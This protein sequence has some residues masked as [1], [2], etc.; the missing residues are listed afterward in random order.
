MGSAG[1][2]A[3]SASGTTPK[4]GA[5]RPER[6][7]SVPPASNL[8][9][10]PVP[11]VAAPSAP[12]GIFVLEFPGDSLTTVYDYILPQPQVCGGNLFVV[13][14]KVDQGNGVYNWSSVDSQIAP[15]TKAGKKAN[16]I[17][18]GVSY[19][20]NT[21]TPNYVLNDPD[22]QSVSCQVSGVTQTY[23][24]YYSAVYKNDYKIFMKALMNKYGTDPNIGYIRFGFSQGGEVYPTCLSQMMS[25]SGYKTLAAFD[26]A[27]ESYITEMTQYEKTLQAGL[28]GHV[29]AL[30]TD[31]NQFGNPPQYSVTDWE[32][33][34]AVS[35]GIGFGNQGLDLS[36]VENYQSGKPC[37][38]D[39][40]SM[41]KT[42]AG[43]VALEMQT[44]AASD[45]TNAA[46]GTG[47]MTVLL[48]FALSLHT[49]VFEVY[50]QDLQVAYDPTSQYYGQYSKAY[51]QVYDQVA[52]SVGYGSV[53]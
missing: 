8:C 28:S 49:Q 19:D 51:Q 47:S 39:W 35:L 21:A 25:L 31:I 3:Q 45:P 17:V 27:W 10:E 24:V 48:P 34:N 41:F 20:K 18:W 42:Y 52:Q 46:G 33:A 29:A 13:W 1:A 14:S 11:G 4:A 5:G 50:V 23:P 22:Y 2:R 9:T 12:H 43:K 30:L 32:A 16:L 15:W 38:S 26:T 53:K 40:C 37:G 36:D 44:I 6:R 7:H